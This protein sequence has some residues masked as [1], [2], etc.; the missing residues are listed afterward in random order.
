MASTAPETRST[1]EELEAI[2]SGSLT[3]GYQTAIMD[4]MARVEEQM[5]SADV[6]RSDL[7]D[8]LGVHP[9]RVTRLLDDPDN[10]TMRTLWR[11]CAA[12]GL[13]PALSVE[14]A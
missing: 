8:R 1:T 3:T 12:V 11:V 5:V 9:S 13:K 10:I 7:A 2:A 6:S 4:V 14:E